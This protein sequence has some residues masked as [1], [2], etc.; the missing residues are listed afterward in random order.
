MRARVDVEL[1]QSKCCGE[2]R[3]SRIMPLN[4]EWRQYCCMEST[5]YWYG[6][7]PIVILIIRLAR[8]PWS[9]K[10]YH[11]YRNKDWSESITK[12]EQQGKFEQIA[13]KYR[14]SAAKEKTTYLRENDLG[15]A[16]LYEHDSESAIRHLKDIY[17]MA[18]GQNVKIIGSNLAL[19]YLQSE[20]TPKALAILEE[21]R[22]NNYIAYFT[23]VLTLLLLN[24]KQDA[25][26]LFTQY[27]DPSD[28]PLTI[29]AIQKLLAFNPRL[30]ETLDAVEILLDKPE[31]W[32]YKPII[33]NLVDQ[34]K[35]EI[36]VEQVNRYDI[37]SDQAAN[38]VK[39]FEQEP[40][41]F[42]SARLKF[43]RSI[44]ATV[45]PRTG[46]YDGVASL[47]GLMLG[48]DNF[49]KTLPIS[50]QLRSE[51]IIFWRQ[52][53]FLFLHTTDFKKYNPASELSLFKSLLP[54][55]AD[56]V[57]SQSERCALYMCPS[58]G[59][60]IRTETIMRE[61]Y[62]PLWID[63]IEEEEVTNSLTLIQAIEVAI[64][65]MPNDSTP[66]ED[67]A[68]RI[69]CY[70]DTVTSST[71]NETLTMLPGILR[72]KLSLFVDEFNA[73]KVKDE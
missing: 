18:A 46:S 49:S 28:D 64:L 13:E 5:S 7:I 43:M 23:Y 4:R 70:P 44:L 65:E 62:N 66:L 34:W 24:E 19:A 40:T 51:L 14:K 35:L 60:S 29:D 12:L 8:L 61:G 68:F 21:L 10:M 58:I 2:N 63:I 20:Q 33:K 57:F 36:F 25:A 48:L 16:A 54:T 55:D 50:E 27:I 42:V 6:L 22:E 31:L 59:S 15:L 32:L 56:Q 52:V 73:K 26:S 38:L 47:Y 1:Q 41:L 11:K 67:L 71:V 39:A 9:R 45:A 17:K 37:L 69:I 3:I 72:S 30:P 53:Y